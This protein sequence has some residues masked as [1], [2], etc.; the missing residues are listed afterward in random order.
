MYIIIIGGGKVG[1]YLAR[2]L[3]AQNHEVSV[4]E[5]D[6][7]KVNWIEEKL[8]S[9]AVSG[10]GSDALAQ[11]R[12]GAE[13]ADLLI[14][15]TN[16]DEDNLVSCQI[17]KYKFNTPRTISLSNN[18]QNE[19]LFDLLGVDVTLSTTSLIL[20]HI[21]EEIPLHVLTRLTAVEANTELVEIE[22]PS[23]FKARGKKIKETPLKDSVCLIVRGEKKLALPL[24][25]ARL[26]PHDRLIVEVNTEKEEELFSLVLGE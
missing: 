12:A 17:A 23:S 18:P 21:E 5:K 9:I 15:T 4:I 25:E 20:E 22:L 24:N 26:E 14:A 10:D 16:D 13:R 19:F 11:E 3:L 6:E 8:G 7:R 1:Y 2:Q